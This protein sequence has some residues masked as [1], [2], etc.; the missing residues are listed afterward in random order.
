MIGPARRAHTVAPVL[1]SIYIEPTTCT[2]RLPAPCTPVCDATG[3]RQ[4]N[5]L[6]TSALTDRLDLE[7]QAAL[8]AGG[9]RNGHHPAVANISWF[10]G[11]HR[12][13]P[14]AGV[15]LPSLPSSAAAA[16]DRPAISNGHT[17][18]RP[19]IDTVVP[20][21]SSNVT[22]TRVG[23]PHSGSSTTAS[24]RP[25]DETPAPP[26][27]TARSRT[28]SRPYP[29]WMTERTRTTTPMA[30]QRATPPP[31]PQSHQHDLPQR[32]LPSR[33]RRASSPVDPPI[34]PVPRRHRY[35]HPSAAPVQ[36]TVPR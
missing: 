32:P 13:R 18:H 5:D 15:T 36:H 20:A 22:R 12:E 10:T 17:W 26:S 25:R 31:H 2:E 23:T 34:A 16:T 4:H 7:R 9:V 30:Y 27:R 28:A 6:P 11:H 21:S 33:S 1:R 24:P 3:T 8:A 29:R 14:L 19:F 35:G